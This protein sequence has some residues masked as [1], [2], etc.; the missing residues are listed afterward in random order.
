MAFLAHYQ[1]QHTIAGDRGNRVFAAADR[2][3]CVDQ[4]LRLQ[5]DQVIATGR[6]LATGQGLGEG[7]GQA[8]HLH[9]GPAVQRHAIE[10][11]VDPRLAVERQDLHQVAGFP[12]GG[13]LRSQA[14][15]VHRLALAARVEQFAAHQRPVAETRRLPGGHWLGAGQLRQF[16]LPLLQRGLVGVVHFHRAE[17]TAGTA[18]TQPCLQAAGEAAK[19]RILAVTEGEQ[20]VAEVVERPRLA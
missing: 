11:G 1:L 14:Q 4:R 13:L 6:Q 18:F 5:T 16:L 3:Q 19:V 12:A 17:R 20:G 10:E 2:H 8:I 15:Q 9:L 7:F